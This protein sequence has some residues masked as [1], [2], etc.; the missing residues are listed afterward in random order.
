MKPLWL[1]G[2]DIETDPPEPVDALL[3]DGEPRWALGGLLDR[4][5]IDPS[6][7]D[8][9]AAVDP[10][11]APDFSWWRQQYFRSPPG[12]AAREEEFV[13]PHP[14]RNLCSEPEAVLTSLLWLRDGL[15]KPGILKQSE[16]WAWLRFAQPYS[17]AGFAER[18]ADVLHAWIEFSER[19]A[20]H[21]WKIAL[22]MDAD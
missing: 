6:Y 14:P 9:H 8:D 3:T 17:A 12:G 1:E 10:P 5:A 7:T 16:V 22:R 15:Q 21:G 19:A 11:A 20:R 2:V 4:L 13:S 18:F